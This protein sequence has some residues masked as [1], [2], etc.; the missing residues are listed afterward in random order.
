MTKKTQG[1]YSPE[2]VRSMHAFL[3]ILPFVIL[4]LLFEMAPAK[5]P[6]ASGISAQIA[7]SSVPWS[8]HSERTDPW[9]RNA[10][11]EQQNF[12]DY[13]IIVK[14]DKMSNAVQSLKAWKEK[15]GYSVKVAK[16]DSIYH[17]VSGRDNAERIWNFLSGNYEAWRTNYVL[18]VG[19]IDELPVRLLY[20]ADKENPYASDFYYAILQ[21]NWDVDNDNRWG[22]FKDDSFWPAADLLVGRI[23]DNDAAEVKKICDNMVAFEKDIGAWKKKAI[24]A[25]GIMGYAKLGSKTD[26]AVT[27]EYMQN[28]IFDQHGWT[29]TTLYEKGGI[30]P[31]SCTPDRSLSEANFLLE[32][33]PQNHSI[34]NLFAHGNPDGMASLT[35]T[36]DIDQDKTID[37]L[38]GEQANNEFSSAENIVSDF[39][40]AFV[41]LCGCSTAPPLG[42]DPL[43]A[44]SPLRSLYLIDIPRNHNAKRYLRHGAVGVIGASAGGDYGPY[45]TNPSDSGTQSLSYYFYDNLINKSNNAGDAFYAAMLKYARDINLR[46]GIMD[47]NFYGDPSLCISGYED[48]PGGTDIVIH[49]GLYYDYAADNA[50]NGDMYVAVLTTIPNAQSGIKTGEIKVYQSTDHGQSWKLWNTISTRQG[51]YSLDLIV[52]KWGS[53]EMVDKRVLVF[54][55]LFDGTVQVHRIEISSGTASTTVIASEGTNNWVWGIK[56]ARDPHAD[57]SNLYLTYCAQNQVV[58]SGVFTTKVCRSLNN[59]NSWQDWASFADYLNPCIEAGVSKN[60]YLA[61][62]K[63][64]Q[65]EDVCVKRSSDAGVTWGD[66]T[67]LS[68]GDGAQSHD[69]CPVAIAASTDEAIP[70][71][72]VVYNYEKSSG[73]Y[74]D[75]IRYAYSKDA[76]SSWTLDQTLAGNAGNEFRFSAKSYRT[77]P[78]RWINIAYVAGSTNPQI[79]WQ[80][81]S[82]SAAYHWSTPRIVN[83]FSAHGRTPRLV[84]SPGVNQSGSGV[85]YGGSSSAKVYFSAPWLSSSRF[86]SDMNPGGQVSLHPVGQKGQVEIDVNIP[87]RDRV[88]ILIHDALGK[89]VATL[90][91]ETMD[92]GGHKLH[93]QG[94]RSNGDPVAN[95]SYLCT[96]QTSKSFSSKP[97]T[98]QQQKTMQK[99]AVPSGGAWIETGDL[100]R[101]FLVSRII[102]STD[103]KLYA[104]AITSVDM[105]RNEGMV[106]RSLNKGTSWEKTGKLEACWAL[107]TILQ[108]SRGAL[109]AGGLMRPDSQTVNGVIYRSENGGDSW[110]PV[111]LFPNGNVY[112]II[113]AGAGVL[114]AATGWNGFIFKSENDGKEW[115]PVIEFGPGVHIYTMLRTAHEML[116]AAGEKPDA[117]GFMM[118]SPDELHWMPLEA[119]NEASAIYDMVQVS[120][121]LVAAGRGRERAWVKQSDAEG[122][123]WSTTGDL[124]RMNIKAVHCLIP[125]LRDEIFAGTEVFSGPSKTNVLI[126]PAPDQNWQIFAG[127]ID[128]ANAVHSILLTPENIYAAT[129]EIYGNIYRC[130][131]TVGFAVDEN[132]DTSLPARMELAQNFP[133]PFNAATTIGYSLSR[134]EKVRLVIYTLP[135]QQ[136]AVLIDEDRPAG[137][138]QITWRGCDAAGRILP[139]GVYLCRM[140]AGEY[141]AVKKMLFLK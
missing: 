53:G 65:S 102:Q 42:D 74:N 109:L 5:N 57:F 47:L 19:D 22:E 131:P 59:G 139:S 82:G 86:F 106:F 101:A 85:V 10:A 15:I 127:D 11:A 114:Y 83:D 119:V 123:V 107:S 38:L 39:V 133:N 121:K 104:S 78:N 141:T 24:L 34:I 16:F 89:L 73:Q 64:N 60:I 118:K 115:R 112:E 88:L 3:P 81:T 58:S 125:T 51:I 41:F 32:V 67:N 13:L 91:N 52:T 95:G 72:W 70:T 93:W 55:S 113:Q 128:L 87:E 61:A 9:Y 29:C 69:A 79:T 48:R 99:S 77:D 100:E 23:P 75:D 134:R 4:S 18:L 31:S 50:D 56:A 30:D 14:D 1:N 117:T 129:G 25:M 120:D 46:R 126:L 27:G 37:V 68:T 43:F 135:G 28:H 63:N 116:F 80:W 33:G 84:Y 26:G 49:D 96:V 130:S 54:S 62:T 40:S 6:V 21:T 92:A 122:V 66:W 36:S 98:W 124:T 12:Y 105:N 7:E 20:P 44:D 140:E 110:A 35:W 108:T 97:F 90:A 45:W 17:A 132:R 138:Y 137:H 76:G 103:Q 111:L 136:V 71:V 94:L 2:S 8:V